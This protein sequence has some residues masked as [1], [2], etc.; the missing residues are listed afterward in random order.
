MNIKQLLIEKERVA[1]INNDPSL[2]QFFAASLDYILDL[3]KQVNKRDAEIEELLD[4]VH[5]TDT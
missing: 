2:A 3:E 1:Y 5:G 4:G